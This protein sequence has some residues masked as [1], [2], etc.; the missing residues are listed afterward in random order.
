M[1][2]LRKMR[3][4]G[5]VLIILGVAVCVNPSIFAD[6]ISARD[7]G[8]YILTGRVLGAIGTVFGVLF[9]YLG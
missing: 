7:A 3:V 8:M 1:A 2:K 6:G 5:I 9:T 4:L